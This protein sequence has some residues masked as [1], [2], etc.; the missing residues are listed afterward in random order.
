MLEG[1]NRLADTLAS[2]AEFRDWEFLVSPGVI[3]SD[4][5]DD[6]SLRVR[7]LESLEEPWDLL[8]SVRALAV[9]TPLG[10][11]FKTTIADAL[12]AGCHVLV[13]P[14][15]AARL[16]NPI[17][18]SCIEFDANKSSSARAIHN[19]LIAEPAGQYV[20]QILKE[21]GIQQLEQAFSD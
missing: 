17:R 4:E 1:F 6:L 3:A 5:P 8:C 19:D 12:D 13:H 16:P 10:F 9:L 2:S 21:A 15:L 14:R 11:G 7:R 18:A 20:N